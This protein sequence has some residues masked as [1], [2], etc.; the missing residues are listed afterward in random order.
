MSLP[1]KYPVVA[2][3]FVAASAFRAC[4]RPQ[5]A[6]SRMARRP[7]CGLLLALGAAGSSA[8][9]GPMV[10]D[11]DGG[12]NEPGRTV[13]RFTWAPT[14]FVAKN[15]VAAVNNFAAFNCQ[16]GAC[17]FDVLSHATMVGLWNGNT[18]V[19]PPGLGTTWEI[20]MT[21]RFTE[22]VTAVAGPAAFFSTTGNGWVEWFYSPVADAQ[23]LTGY[24]FNNGRLIMRLNGLLAASPGSLT[25]ANTPP[26]VLDGIG[27][28]DFPGQ[29]TV[30]ATGSPGVLSF[31]AS[32]RD[33]DP[34]FFLSNWAALDLGGSLPAAV[35]YFGVDPSDC[36]V[37][38]QAAVN[39]GQPN[40]A[41]PGCDKLHVLGPFS[42][43]LAANGGYVPVTGFINGFH[44]PDFDP[45]IAFEATANVVPEP[46]RLALLLAGLLVVAAR[47]LHPGRLSSPSP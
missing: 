16:Q 35:P 39:V 18:D 32:G 23:A 27:P 10:F 38:S 40:G 9:A 6:R 21:M 17:D 44:G 15:G 42:Q 29:L 41:L 7:V 19:T 2:S 13:T 5:V 31:G 43:Q 3:G 28:D 4:I 30:A 36:F 26:V 8:I 22:T 14:S 25:I 20:T 37:T 11:P 47:R 46:G 33:V 34:S 1:V 24:G 12:G 45:E